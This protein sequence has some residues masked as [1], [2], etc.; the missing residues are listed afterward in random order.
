MGP[1]AGFGEASG[2][3]VVGLEIERLVW[4]GIRR[5][6]DIT[7]LRGGAGIETLGLA[8]ISD[9]A[10]DME[11]VRTARRPGATDDAEAEVFPPE[12]RLFLR[13]SW[14]LP[15][16]EA[17]LDVDSPGSTNDVGGTIGGN[18]MRLELDREGRFTTLLGVDVDVVE[19]IVLGLVDLIPTGRLPRLGTTV[20]PPLTSLAREALEYARGLARLDD[21]PAVVERV[22]ERE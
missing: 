2:V 20:V 13:P 11:V 6:V 18:E 14:L 12:G 5:G 1:G 21:V 7:L 8:S 19:L 9:S 22:D 15:C 16:D 10:V 3:I 17:R 4:E